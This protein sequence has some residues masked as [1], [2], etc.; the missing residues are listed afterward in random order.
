MSFD[1]PEFIEWAANLPTTPEREQA[2]LRS[3]ISRAYYGCF[4]PARIRSPFRDA[5]DNDTHWR[6]I[7]FYKYHPAR[8]LNTIGKNL[9]ILRRLRNSADYDDS[10][11]FKQVDATKAIN[12]AKKILADLARV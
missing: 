3:V 9:D 12:V 2:R 11:S 1:W 7:R 5:I 6:V 8:R 4:H 10:I